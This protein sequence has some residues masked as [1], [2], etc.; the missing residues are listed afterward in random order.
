MTDYLNTP[1]DLTDPDLASA[2]DEVSLWSYP[3]GR[4]ILDKRDAVVIIP[5]SPLEVGK[6]Y[7]VTLVVNGETITWSFDAVSPPR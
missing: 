3:F 6:S 4:L 5:R 1:F 2:F 7:T